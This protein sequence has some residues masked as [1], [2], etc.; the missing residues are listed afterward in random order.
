MRAAQSSHSY[1]CSRSSF[2]LQM[3]IAMFGLAYFVAHFQLEFRFASELCQITLKIA[4]FS[5]AKG[6]KNKTKASQRADEMKL[7]SPL[8][9]SHCHF[10]AVCRLNC[11]VTFFSVSLSHRKQFEWIATMIR[12]S[13]SS[14]HTHFMNK[15]KNRKNCLH[16]NEAWAEKHSNSSVSVGL[17]F[18]ALLYHGIQLCERKGNF[19]LFFLAFVWGNNFLAN[20]DFFR[21]LLLCSLKSVG[22]TQRD[23]RKRRSNAKKTEREKNP[24]KPI[25]FYVFVLWNNDSA[26]TTA[27]AHKYEKWLFLVWFAKWSALETFIYIS[28]RLTIESHLFARQSELKFW[29]VFFIAQIKKMLFIKF[30]YYSWPRHRLVSLL[31]LTFS[32][33]FFCW[34]IIV[35]GDDAAA[36]A[37]AF[38]SKFRIIQNHIKLRDGWIRTSSQAQPAQFVHLFQRTHI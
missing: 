21:L 10:L 36:A 17:Q 28:A 26:T 3:P 15:Y 20:C 38:V 35:T 34:F 4:Q 8:G 30:H 6:K 29:V 13:A 1:S 16:E 32:F 23:T 5:E 12:R 31:L 22:N 2:D 33:L 19:V 11:I 24:Y 14:H 18:T 37:A 9:L 7:S 25:K 27:T